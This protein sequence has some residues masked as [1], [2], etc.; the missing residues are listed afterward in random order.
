MMEEPSGA[1]AVTE[2]RDM[3]LARGMSSWLEAAV[4]VAAFLARAGTVGTVTE[5]AAT[6]CGRMRKLWQG[7]RADGGVMG[8]AFQAAGPGRPGTA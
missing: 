5:D 2:S 6:S 3:P 8:G 1:S 4:P 7:S